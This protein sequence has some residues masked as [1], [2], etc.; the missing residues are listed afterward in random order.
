[1]WS[2]ILLTATPEVDALRRAVSGA[3]GVEP[4]EVHVLTGAPGQDTSSA[5]VVVEIASVRGDFAALV[6][7]Y[8]EQDLESRGSLAG[9]AAICRELDVSAF[10]GDDSVNPSSG[11][12]VTAAGQVEAAMIDP[13]AETAGEYRLTRRKWARPP[14]ND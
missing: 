3:F 1:M 9:L 14:P 10:I 11:Y 4:T 2:S 7:V 13:E 6:E 8:P 5:R 12:L